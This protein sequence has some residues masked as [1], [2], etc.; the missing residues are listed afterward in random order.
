MRNVIYSDMKKLLSVTLPILVAQLSTMGINFINTTM[1][2]H[3]GADDLAGVSVGSGIFFPFEAAAIGLLM[4]GTPIIAQL[5][6]KKDRQSVPYI[7]RTG[8]YIAMA[9]SLLFVLGYILFIDRVLGGMGLEDGVRHIAK[10]YILAM[11]GAVVFISL[12]IPFRALTDTV[13]STATSMKLF[14]LALP[15]N[16]VLNYFLI[17]GHWGVPELGGIGAGIS[18][19][20]TYFVILLM[21]LFIIRNDDRLMGKE[22]FS[23]WRTRISDWKEYMNV[24]IPS[25]LSVFMEMGLF[26]AIIVF[27]AKFGTETLAAYQIA[28]NFAN[29]AYMIPLSCSMA[30]TILVARAAGAKDQEMARRYAKA[31]I[32]L[33][34]GFSTIEVLLTVVLRKYIGLI[35]T[36]D[37]AVIAIASQFLLFASA[38]QFFDSVAGPAQGILRGYK[39]TRMPFVFLLI[40]YWGAC[41]PISLF[42]DHFMA[43][44]SVSYWIGLDVGV[45]V[46]AVLMVIRLFVLENGFAVSRDVSGEISVSP[47]AYAESGMLLTDA[48]AAYLMRENMAWFR[49]AQPCTVLPYAGSLFRIENIMLPQKRILEI[50]RHMLTQLHLNVIGHAVRAYVP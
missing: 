26:G 45:G 16:A 6:G 35:Y 9:I 12:I 42:L 14:L 19:A 13:G 28:D 18:A 31:G 27:M 5:L 23:S 2:G 10:Y 30:L 33:S 29:M 25:G 41:L 32:L 11:V 46:A 43:L 50:G 39:D 15:V 3:A 17:F 4:A 38:F 24:G 1:A 8:L 36:D 22:I 44:E 47:E 21:F 20:I 37:H 40:A 34:V 49:G 48:E 7:V